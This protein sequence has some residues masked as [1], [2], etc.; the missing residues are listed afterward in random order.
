[1]ARYIDYDYTQ[2]KFVPMRIP[3]Q[4]ITDSGRSRSVSPVKP[5]TSRSEATRQFDYGVDLH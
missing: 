2:S 1:M 5:I 3:V 4:P